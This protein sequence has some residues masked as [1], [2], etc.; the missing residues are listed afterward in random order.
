MTT[1]FTVA[2]DESLNKTLHTKP[3]AALPKL[4]H[5]LID[6]LTVISLCRFKIHETFARDNQDSVKSKLFSQI[7]CARSQT[8]QES[9]AYHQVKSRSEN[10]K[11]Q[12]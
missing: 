1:T 3:S 10:A 8:V 9:S 5:E 2:G 12:K 6:Q 7:R 4:A 11:P